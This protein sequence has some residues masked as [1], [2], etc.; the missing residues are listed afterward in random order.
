[1]RQT[2]ERESLTLGEKIGGGLLEGLQRTG[3]AESM[4][5]LFGGLN[6]ET[7]GVAAGITGILVAAD[8][9]TEGL[10][11]AAEEFEDINRSVVLFTGNT[12]TAL[13]DLQAHADN[14]VGALD[15][16]TKTLGSDMAILSTRLGMEAGPALD[17]LTRHVEELRDRFGAININALAGGFH[18]FGLEGEDADNALAS[19]METSQRLGVSLPEMVNTFSTS[20]ATLHDLGLN[21]EQAGAFIGKLQTLG[22]AGAGGIEVLQRAMKEAG[23][24]GKDLTSFLKDEA[25]FFASDA[26]DAAKDAEA[27]TVFGARK[28][29]EARD[30]LN[31]YQDIVKEGPDLHK[32][33]GKSIDEVTEKT[34]TLANKW[35]KADEQRQARCRIRPRR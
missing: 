17:K 19:L 25:N 9:L 33:E 32:T 26:T 6:A 22:P 11:E 23:K 3:L 10:V 12:G 15:T 20:G 4:S 29:E 5:G 1:M 2:A 14:L 28:W 7:L 30:A 34:E 8:K 24:Q 27:A 35:D 31:A 18:R 13:D 16:S 21:A